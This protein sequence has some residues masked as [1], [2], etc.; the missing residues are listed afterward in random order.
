MTWTYTQKTGVLT[1]DGRV[2]G[3]GYSGIDAGL[4]NPAMEDDH[5]VGPIP[6]GNWKIGSVYSSD[7]LGPMVMNL[8]TVGHDAHGRS[9]FR[10]HGDNSL[11]N[12]TASHGCIIMARPIRQLVASTGDTTLVVV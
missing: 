11:G 7:H 1:H 5:G 6:R 2:I 9:L 3:Y 4:N 10:M 12:H 8:D